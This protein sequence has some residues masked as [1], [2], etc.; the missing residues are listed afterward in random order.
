MRL[1]GILISFPYNKINIESGAGRE[2]VAIILQYEVYNPF[3]AGIQPNKRFLISVNK[4]RTFLRLS[5]C[6]FKQRTKFRQL[7]SNR[8]NN[9]IRNLEA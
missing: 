8:V 2:R 6:F 7:Y 5:I 4:T 1:N 9:R 3:K